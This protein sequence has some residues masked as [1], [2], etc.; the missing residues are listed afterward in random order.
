MAPSPE[1]L[2]TRRHPGSAQREQLHPRGGCSSAGQDADGFG[3][4]EVIQNHPWVQQTSRV[5]PLP[6]FTPPHHAHLAGQVSSC[7][8]VV[9][10]PW[11]SWD[12]P[13]CPQ[14]LPAAPGL[15]PAPTPE[16]DPAL[17]VPPSTAGFAPQVRDH[18]LPS[19]HPRRPPGV[20]LH[21]RALSPLG[22][23]RSCLKDICVLP[24]PPPTHGPAPQ[25]RL[26]G[27]R[28]GGDAAPEQSQQE[29]RHS[30]GALLLNHSNMARQW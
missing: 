17:P 15:A 22:H 12:L 6:V 13:A 27:R 14:S 2:G 28:G 1:Q 23:H 25:P 10:W 5:C 20:L 19:Q 18:I 30:R 8:S 3:V 26:L 24:I 7:F 16:P 21:T 11:C 4:F 9:S 29:G